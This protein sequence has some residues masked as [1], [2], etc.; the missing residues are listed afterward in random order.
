MR[1][2]ACGASVRGPAHTQDDLPNQDALGIRGCNGGWHIA[3]ADGLGSRPMSHV[4][5]RKAVQLFG[6]LAR[7]QPQLEPA[8]VGGIL[9]AQWLAHFGSDYHRFES[10]CL[11]A[12]VNDYGRGFAGQVGDGL[13][14]CRSG[15]VFR[16]MTPPREGFGNQTHT[17]AYA[18]S[19]SSTSIQLRLSSPGDGVLLL[20]DGISDDLIHEQLEPFFDVIYQRQRRSSRRRMRSWLTHELQGWSTPMHGDDKT[21][22]G[23][24]RLD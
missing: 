8:E 16:V 14:L 17:L 7:G 6:R 9:R 1:L 15:G 12:H 18:D 23:I 21:I 24:F 4:G 2:S 5:S 10:T 22:A 3:V 11:W 13:V 19:T 20:T